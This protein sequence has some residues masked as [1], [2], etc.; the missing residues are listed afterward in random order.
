MAIFNPEFRPP[1]QPPAA[2]MPAEINA[3]WADPEQ[4]ETLR[5]SPCLSWRDERR[6]CFTP[7]AARCVWCGQAVCGTHRSADV[8]PSC[9]QSRAHLTAHGLVTR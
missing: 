3:G 8:C 5:L 9:A 7:A 2:P 6:H 4:R 1:H